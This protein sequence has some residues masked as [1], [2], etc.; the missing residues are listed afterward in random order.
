V[1]TIL[2]AEDEAVISMM[3]TQMLEM[4]GHTVV[5]VVNTGS[6]AV[7]AVDQSKPDLLLMD[8]AMKGD[9]DGISACSIIK[10][11]NPAVKVVFLSAYPESIFQEALSDIDYDGY[12]VKPAR[13]NR[14][15][16][17][18]EELGF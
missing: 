6:K 10:D 1:A 9:Q 16:S 12:I 14:I 4:I 15:K 7:E 13:I 11:V 18:L 3:L 2:I 5:D 17:Y 8:I